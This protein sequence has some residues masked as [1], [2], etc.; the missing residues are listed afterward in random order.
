MLKNAIIILVL[1]IFSFKASA[2]LQKENLLCTTKKVN[3]LR[4]LPTQKS[5][6][7]RSLPMYTPLK[8]M[9]KNKNWYK[10]IGIYYNGWIHE[11]IVR[12]DIECMIF[13]SHGS[14]SCPG[15]KNT[16]HKIRFREGFKV[17]KKEIGCNYVQTSIGR[18]FW[19]DSSYAWPIEEN[20]SLHLDN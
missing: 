19:I 5:A 12:S 20:L 17:L 13:T 11:S 1:I 16:T 15:R 3:F 9:S 8:V 18:R 10:V 7:V 14:P 4:Q 6:I 2:D